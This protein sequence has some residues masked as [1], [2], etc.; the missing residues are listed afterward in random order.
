MLR[1]IRV[2][3]MTGGTISAAISR[4]PTIRVETATVIAVGP[5][6]ATFRKAAGTPPTRATSSSSAT[7]ASTR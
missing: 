6:S 7:A 2:A 1:A 3:A 4:I 5:A